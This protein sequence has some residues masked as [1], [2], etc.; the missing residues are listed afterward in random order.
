MTA[1]QTQ[2][3]RNQQELQKEKKNLEEVS[4]ERKQKHD[5]VRDKRK[6]LASKKKEQV[7]KRKEL[8]AL[9]IKSQALQT[10]LDQKRAKIEGLNRIQVEKGNQLSQV[11]ARLAE[12]E[13]IQ[14]GLRRKRDELIQAKQQ[15]EVRIQELDHEIK[16]SIEK[17]DALVV[18]RTAEIE[19]VIALHD[20][21]VKVENAALQVNTEVAAIRNEIARKQEHFHAAKE[22]R[23]AVEKEWE[24]QNNRN[25]RKQVA[26]NQRKQQLN[27]YLENENQL[28]IEEVEELEYEEEHRWT[29]KV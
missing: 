28:E 5:K 15:S 9:Q 7:T 23:V 21:I 18:E 10:N 3:Q 12:N 25:F 16:E 26:L 8:V 29:E 6:K 17:R 24:Y 14:D 11:Q 4:V 27:E 1:K 2:L 22:A 13:K 20:N 19:K